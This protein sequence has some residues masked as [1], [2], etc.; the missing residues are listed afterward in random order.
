MSNHFNKQCTCF[1][2][3]DQKLYFAFYDPCD[4]LEPGWPLRNLLC[5]LFYSCPDFT[6]SKTINILSLRGK[7]LESSI[8]FS[9]KTKGDEKIL[10]KKEIIEGRLVGWEANVNGKMGPNIADLSESLDPN[11]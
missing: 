1:L 2:Q 9:I 10:D 5:L 6:Y 7:N 4:T 3:I 11:R 8:I